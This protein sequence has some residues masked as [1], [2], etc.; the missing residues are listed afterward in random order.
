MWQSNVCC[1]LFDMSV[2]LEVIV[3][4]NSPSL[5]FLVGE[6]ETGRGRQGERKGRGRV[7]LV[8]TPLVILVQYISL[9]FLEQK[10]AEND[11][12]D[13]VVCS[14]LFFYIV[15]DVCV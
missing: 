4:I 14:L 12:L 2:S 15:T 1:I 7:I 11:M 6:R 8:V 9:L 10:D 13:P 5:I 3:L